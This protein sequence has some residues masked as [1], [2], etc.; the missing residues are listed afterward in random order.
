MQKY[1]Y[2]AIAIASYTHLITDKAQFLFIWLDSTK[3]YAHDANL[4]FRGYA[5]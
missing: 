5:Y 2:K 1:S 4:R 3:N